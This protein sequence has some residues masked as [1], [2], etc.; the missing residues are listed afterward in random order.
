MSPE[1]FAQEIIQ[2]YGPHPDTPSATD[3]RALADRIAERD[4][5]LAGHYRETIPT[6]TE[7]PREPRDT[8]PAPAPDSQV[9]HRQRG[10]VDP[11]AFGD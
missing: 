9:P 7:E 8:E 4:R 1:A 6:L 2:R 5:V 10:P 11:E 3:M